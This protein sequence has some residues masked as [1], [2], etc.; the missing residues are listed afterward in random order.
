MDRRETSSKKSVPNGPDD[1]SKK[2]SK[3]KHA[4]DDRSH[5]DVHPSL[6]EAEFEKLCRGA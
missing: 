6:L 1:S 4:V 5:R 3:K 2:K